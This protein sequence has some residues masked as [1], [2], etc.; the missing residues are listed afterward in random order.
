M[1]RSERARWTEQEDELIL[2]LV[3][4]G[5]RDWAG[6]AEKI[7]GRT[8]DAVRNHWHR[9]VKNHDGLKVEEAEEK[10]RP[11]RQ[12]W[13]TEEDAI[14]VAAVEELGKSWR[15]VAK[16]LPPRVDN[17]KQRSDSSVR[18]R[19]ERLMKN[20]GGSDVSPPQSGPPSPVIG[21]A[22]LVPLDAV[23]DTPLH[24]GGDAAQQPSLF[25][26]FISGL[27][28]SGRRS[29]SCG[30]EPSQTSV[31]PVPL[32]GTNACR[33]GEQERDR[34]RVCFEESSKF[35]VRE[36]SARGPMSGRCESS[37][38]GEESSRFSV[39]KDGSCADLAELS[40]RSMRIEGRS[41]DSEVEVDDEGL[42]NELRNA[43]GLEATPKGKSPFTDFG[44]PAFHA[45][46]PVTLEAMPKR[47]SDTLIGE[48]AEF[49]FDELLNTSE[50][51][52]RMHSP[53]KLASPA[54]AS[55]SC[56]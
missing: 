6:L 25:A 10:P 27:S 22:T 4:T 20:R 55:V 54:R 8:A 19:W 41:R 11:D 56:F 7:G 49:D 13:S 24:P 37:A 52:L 43:L 44:M 29:N 35:S 2:N 3:A 51:V 12:K 53:N 33:T 34:A 47:S 32:F 36:Y 28:L 21:A 26:N 15:E 50:Q 30:T 39:R 46:E 45:P 40:E 1:S 18:N 48:L 9:L 38:W 17:G 23:P 31:P 5:S 16:R 42:C 14:I